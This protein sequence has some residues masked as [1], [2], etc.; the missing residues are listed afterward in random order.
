MQG[1]LESGSHC[2]QLSAL[3]LGTLYQD[4]PMMMD[5]GQPQPE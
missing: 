4:F 3:R 1:T 5:L 2:R